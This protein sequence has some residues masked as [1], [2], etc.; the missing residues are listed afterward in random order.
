M[1]DIKNLEILLK[2]FIER[3]GEDSQGVKDIKRAIEEIKNKS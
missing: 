1:E 3:F 2:F